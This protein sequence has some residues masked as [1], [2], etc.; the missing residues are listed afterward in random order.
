MAKTDLS[1]EMEN[2]LY[3]ASLNA[4]KT[5]LKQPTDQYGFELETELH[6]LFLTKE[7]I[8]D[9]S[10]KLLRDFPKSEMV[11]YQD[12]G[13]A[14]AYDLG[15]LADFS[16]IF[17]FG[18]DFSQSP[19]CVDCRKIGENP[20]IFWDTGRLSWRQIADDVVSFFKLFN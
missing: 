1:F 8:L 20:V 6:R 7:H 17:T 18:Y 9:E 2:C 11:Y 10:Q 15:Y 16:A 4:H 12:Y 3:L 19:F 13:F 5:T 14:N